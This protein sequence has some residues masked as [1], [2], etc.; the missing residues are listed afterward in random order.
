MD[1]SY[2]FLPYVVFVFGTLWCRYFKI[3]ILYIAKICPLNSSLIQKIRL[4]FA[5]SSV[6]KY[7]RFILYKSIKCLYNEAFDSVVNK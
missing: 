1:R 3:F 6:L 5:V 7:V 2:M 4:V